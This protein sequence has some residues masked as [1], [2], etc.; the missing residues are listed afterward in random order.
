MKEP[1]I[2]NLPATPKYLLQL[3]QQG[4]LNLRAYERALKIIGFTPTAEKWNRFLNILLLV[5]GA[6]LTV[7][8]IYFF[9]AYNWADM[10]RFVKLGIVEALILGMALAA[11]SINLNKLPG[12]IALTVAAVLIGALLAV[13]GQVYQTGADSYRLF[14]TWVILMAGWVFISRFAPLWFIWI[15]LINVTLGLYWRQIVGYRYATQ[16]W[17]WIFIVNCLF[18]LLW[19]FSSRKTDWL[20]SR[21]M[22]RLLSLPVFYAATAAAVMFVINE[23]DRDAYI[24]TLSILFITVNAIVLYMYSQRI[25][26]LFM[27]TISAISLMVVFDTWLANVIEGAGDFVPLIIGVIIIA[28]TALTVT[29]LLRTSR[30]WEARNP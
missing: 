7:S 6:G 17:L 22:P 18:L 1:D 2:A 3:L 27:L 23:R 8:G 29:L 24:I 28:Q 15:L 25:L 16:L 26:D 19:E 9:F 14:L 11:F 13:F 10:H 20:F 21:W 30:S 4:L 12:K 5:L